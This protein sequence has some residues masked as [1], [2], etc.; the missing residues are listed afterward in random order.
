MKQCK[1]KHQYILKLV[2]KADDG[3]V[4]YKLL[5]IHSFPTHLVNQLM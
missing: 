5:L 2:P 3:N 4:R 1:E